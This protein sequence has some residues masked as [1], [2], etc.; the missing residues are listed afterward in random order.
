ML[1]RELLWV[2]QQI[3]IY[4]CANCFRMYGDGFIWPYLCRNLKGDTTSRYHMTFTF[5][6]IVR[7]IPHTY[8]YTYT[9]ASLLYRSM[10]FNFACSKFIHCTFL[11]YL[12]LCA[13]LIDLD[14]KQS[15]WRACWCVIWIQSILLIGLLALVIIFSFSFE[16]SLFSDQS[17]IKLLG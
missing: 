2:K 10:H 13:Q 6:Y 3:Q 7:F 12:L 15:R 1:V 8:T 5:E 16:H 14:V 4:S 11:R 9:V 17:W